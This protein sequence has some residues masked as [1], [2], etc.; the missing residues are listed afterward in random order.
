M[1]YSFKQLLKMF[2]TGKPNPYTSKEVSMPAKAYKT[3][4]INFPDGVATTTNYYASVPDYTTWTEPMEELFLLIVKDWRN[5]YQSSDHN[6]FHQKTGITFNKTSRTWVT[7]G[8]PEYVTNL[9][10]SPA[11]VRDIYILLTIWKEVHYGKKLARIAN[12]KRYRADNKTKQV[13]AAEAQK[14]RDYLEGVGK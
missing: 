1:E 10:I 8:V 12:I 11:C 7:E 6:N 3:Y 14:I 4:V 5:W 2:F 13:L 9:S